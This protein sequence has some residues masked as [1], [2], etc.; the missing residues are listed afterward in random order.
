[1]AVR[2]ARAARQDNVK[3]PPIIQYTENETSADW[4]LA[5]VACVPLLWRPRR[6]LTALSSEDAPRR[7]QATSKRFASFSNQRVNRRHQRVAE[8][9]G[10]LPITE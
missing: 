2:T 3:R 5:G 1:V 10:L 6:A 9:A 4:L 7:R 8:G